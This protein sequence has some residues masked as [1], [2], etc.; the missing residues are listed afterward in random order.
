ML[1]QEIRKSINKLEEVTMEYVKN[2]D[3]D[4]LM[5]YKGYTLGALTH[6]EPDVRKTGYDIFKKIRDG[7][8]EFK[9]KFHSQEF[10]RRV[11]SLNVSSYANTNE[12]ED[13]FKKAIDDMQLRS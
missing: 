5:D 9:G 7:G 11:E 8:F 6:D 13:I 12:A 4:H 2:R 1:V 10:Y 3:F